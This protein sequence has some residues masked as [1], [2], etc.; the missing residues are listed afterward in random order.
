MESIVMAGSRATGRPL[1][2]RTITGRYGGGGHD[3]QISP[4]IV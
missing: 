2:G 3:S 4:E 1:L